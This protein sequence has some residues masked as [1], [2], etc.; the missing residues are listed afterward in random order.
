MMHGAT[1]R[2]GDFTEVLRGKIGSTAF[3]IMADGQ[4]TNRDLDGIKRCITL[5]MELSGTENVE[6]N[7]KE[8]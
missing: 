4:I 8:S 6:E 7:S 5:T 1:A 3:K 2:P